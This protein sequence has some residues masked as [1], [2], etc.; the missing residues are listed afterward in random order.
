M[1]HEIFVLLGEYGLLLVFLN[2][3]VTQLGMPLPAVPTLVVAGALTASGQ[4]VLPAVL[5]VALLAC[6]IGD[7]LWYG[8]GRR[9]GGHVMRALCRI[10]LSPDSCVH[11]SEL[12]F[13]RWRG[14][15]LLI[16][17]F[18]PGL[19]TVAPPL[20]GAMGLGFLSFIVFDG[21]GSVLWA[22]VAVVLGSTFAAQL[23]ML[24]GMLADAGALALELLLGLLALYILVRW[25][26]RH[27]LLAALR[28]PRIAPAELNLALT[29][30][31]APLVLDVR[32]VP[33]RALDRR[34]L[35]GALLA[36]EQDQAMDKLLRGVVPDRELVLYCNC[37]HEAT[38][39]KAAKALKARGY[40]HVRPLAGGLDAWAAAGYAV[41]W[42]PELPAAKAAEVPAARA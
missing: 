21:I 5:L 12:Q 1:A 20:V 24:L 9:Y 34:V 11:R 16:A 17:K 33:A 32:S 13:Q 28:M 4:L 8:A 36:D 23:D 29:Q 18:V 41:E 14:G 37:P 22:G 25:W 3:L 7:T 40:R 2:V 10:S 15:V 38:A 26:Q 35:P 6:L 30:G 19:S 31:Q 39:A 27:R 42:L